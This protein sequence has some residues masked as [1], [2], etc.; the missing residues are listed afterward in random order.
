MNTATLENGKYFHGKYGSF[1]KTKGWFVG[2]FFDEGNPCKT[3]KLEVMYKEHNKG[4]LQAPHYHKIKVELLLILEGK[5]KYKVNDEEIILNKGD[6]LFVDINNIISGEF[7]EP[8][9]IFAVH[10]PSIP[11]DKVVVG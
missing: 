4:D 9:K 6:F 8:S 5:A 7:L 3:G 11:T 2:S 10:S 1:E